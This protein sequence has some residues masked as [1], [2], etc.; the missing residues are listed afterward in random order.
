MSSRRRAMQTEQSKCTCLLKICCYSTQRF[1]QLSSIL[2]KLKNICTLYAINSKNS[3]QPLM[4]MNI[5]D[6]H[7]LSVTCWRRPVTTFSPDQ[8]REWMPRDDH[9]LIMHLRGMLWKTHIRHQDNTP[10]YLCMSKNYRCWWLKYQHVGIVQG[11]PTHGCY[12]TLARHRWTREFGHG[13]FA[14]M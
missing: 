11:I 12:D 14:F 8:C 6:R 4:R 5:W 2:S 7:R 13:R 10:C 1:K 3:Y 9:V